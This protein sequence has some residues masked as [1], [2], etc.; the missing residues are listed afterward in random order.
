MDFELNETQVMFRS[1]ARDFTQKEIKP[2]AQFFDRQPDPVKAIP[3]DL[4]RKGFNLDLHKMVIP[5]KHGGMGL[6]AVTS[7]IILEELAAGDPGYA[8]TWHVNNIAITFLYNIGNE[9]QALEWIKPIIGPDGGVSAITTTEPDG[10][11]TSSQIIEPTLFTY[12]TTARL[13]GEYWVVNGSKVFCSNAG[14][15]FNRWVMTFCRADMSKVGAAS[16]G[17]IVVPMGTSGF[18][19]VGEED[20]MGH[21]LSSTVSLSYSDVR[22]PRRNS[23][24]GGVRTITYDHDSAV[25]AIA[26]GIARSAYEAAVDYA[27]TR[28]VMERPIIQYQLIQNKIA[29]MFTGLEAARAL[30][31]RTASYSDSH[32]VMDVKLARA[33]KIFA[34]ETAMKIVYDALQIFG[35]AG[36]TKATAVEKAYRDIRVSTIYEGTN[37][38]LRISLA[39]LV[40]AGL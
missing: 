29:D 10:G 1:M 5:E 34:T 11:T 3:V 4:L 12:K 17:V 8:L 36:Y 6:D 7:C 30:V 2:V 19:V 22:V 39:K 21:R 25:G 26:I 28:L 32:P 14:L 13:D 35:G 24:S 40:E 23:L 33:V 37:E 9:A 38:A 20:K 15:P 18:E 31:F 27:R 16:M